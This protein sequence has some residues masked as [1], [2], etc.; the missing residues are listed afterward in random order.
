MDKEA[1]VNALAG[2]ITEKLRLVSGKSELHIMQAL[3]GSLSLT[4][5]M[6]LL[7]LPAATAAAAGVVS[8]MMRNMYCTVDVAIECCAVKHRSYDCAWSSGRM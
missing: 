1:E 4:L 3:S 5:M 8:L 7:Q 6:S 2:G